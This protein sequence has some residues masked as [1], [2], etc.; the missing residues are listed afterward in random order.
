LLVKPTKWDAPTLHYIV[1][2]RSVDCCVGV[3]GGG[4]ETEDEE[5][6]PMKKQRLQSPLHG[7]P[8]IEEPPQ[9]EMPGIPLYISEARELL[10]GSVA[11]VVLI[12]VPFFCF[13]RKFKRQPQERKFLWKTKM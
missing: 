8:N 9:L 13:E 7:A 1:E 6:R 2:S 11:L 12:V 10:A 5:G 4:A 3:G